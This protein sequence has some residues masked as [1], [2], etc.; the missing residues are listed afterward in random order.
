M[1]NVK[2]KLRKSRK[3][4]NRMIYILHGDPAVI[5]LAPLP[6]YAVLS[7]KDNAGVMSAPFSL[8]QK[9]SF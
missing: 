6:V 1:S 3:T 8:C 5:Y 2:V 4:G 9:Y 7:L